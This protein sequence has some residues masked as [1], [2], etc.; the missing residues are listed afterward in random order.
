MASEALR[1]RFRQDLLELHTVA[2]D[3]QEVVGDSIEHH[4]VALKLAQRQANHLSRGL[5]QIQRLPG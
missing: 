2:G 5:V 1:T 4:P 3:G